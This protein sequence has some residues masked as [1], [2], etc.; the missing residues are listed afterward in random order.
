MRIISAHSPLYSGQ[1]YHYGSVW[2]LFTGWASVGEYRYHQTFPAYANLR[3]NALLALDGSLGHVAEVLSGDYYQPLSTNSPHQ[4]WSAAMVI[5]PILRGMLALDVDARSHT[6]TFA[7]HVP[8]N[9]RSLSVDN[10]QL[11]GAKLALSYKRTPGT[12]TLEVKRTGSG[13]DMLDFSPSLSLRSEVISVELNGHRLAFHT[14]LN[15]SDQHVAMRI[16]IGQALSTIRIRLKND[17]GISYANALPAL[18]SASQGL[19]VL[20]DTWN[21]GRTQLT[22][23]LS[24]LPGKKYELAVWNPSLVASVHGGKLANVSAD[25]GTLAVEFPAGTGNDF[26]RQDVVLNFAGTR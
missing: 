12:L 14:D 22:L 19:R 18:G 2:P 11:G 5:S 15:T 9:W 1:G 25:E 17:F 24:G 21:A 4:I 16:P 23:S 6:L 20:S 13:E 3:S 7:P 26:V 10:L 8:A